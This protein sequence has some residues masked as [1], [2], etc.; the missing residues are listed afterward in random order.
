MHT[1]D[2]SGMRIGLDVGGSKIEGIL[3]GPGATELAR[4]RV[5]TPR[6]DYSATIA[7]IVDLMV[8]L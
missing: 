7:A 4:Y 6:N 1:S 2:Q 3:V 8:H 5:P